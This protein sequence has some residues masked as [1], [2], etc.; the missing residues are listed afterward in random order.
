MSQLES[1]Y[2]EAS[3]KQTK[4]FRWAMWQNDSDIQEQI[5]TFLTTVETAF[6]SKK[7]DIGKASEIISLHKAGNI[8]GIKKIINEL[9]N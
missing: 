5:P 2:M 4:Y 8:E 9:S 6:F 7:L 3:N 1:N